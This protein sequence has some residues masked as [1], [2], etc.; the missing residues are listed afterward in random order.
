MNRIIEIMK[1]GGVG[2]G[3]LVKGPGCLRYGQL[4]IYN[5]LRYMP[6]EGQNI[7]KWGDII[8]IHGVNL[9]K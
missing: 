1:R 5:L 3:V 2:G 6:S 4:V 8:R 7:L 9:S